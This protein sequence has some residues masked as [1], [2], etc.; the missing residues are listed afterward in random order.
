[1]SDGGVQTII[2][3]PIPPHLTEAYA[4]LGFKKG[5][6]PITEEIADTCISLPIYNGLEIDK[7]KKVVEVL[8]A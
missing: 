7:I 5:V 6:F 3:Y 8:N 1:M 2:H 4:D